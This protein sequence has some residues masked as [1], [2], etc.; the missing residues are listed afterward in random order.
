MQNKQLPVI[1]TT[2]PYNGII[3]TLAYP[4]QRGEYFLVGSAYDADTNK[5]LTVEQYRQQINPN[6]KLI[7]WA[8]C[9][10]LERQ[11]TQSLITQPEEIEAANYY[12]MLEILPPAR[13]TH[14][15]GFEVFHVIERITDNLVH[16]YAKSNGKYYKF[17]DRA[18]IDIKK[19]G[20]KLLN[21][22]QN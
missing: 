19:L 5:N 8:E 7:S 9:A 14:I 10:K 12:E 16:W 20:Q 13:W 18:N 17:I 3:E 2:K 21:K 1:D 4:G 22:A 6:I 11:Y 15:V